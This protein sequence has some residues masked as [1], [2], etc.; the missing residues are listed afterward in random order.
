MMDQ[1]EQNFP[2][3]GN[4]EQRI[5]QFTGDI[6]FSSTRQPFAREGFDHCRG[7]M[8]HLRR[9]CRLCYLG[10]ERLPIAGRHPGAAGSPKG[11]EYIQC[12]RGKTG[13]QRLSE[14]RRSSVHQPEIDASRDSIKRSR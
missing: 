14:H 6:R 2:V 10:S 13:N 12:V 1:Q 7:G 3:Q 9:C 5:P 8:R 4:P 11:R